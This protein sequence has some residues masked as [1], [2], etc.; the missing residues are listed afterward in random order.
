[1]C[2]AA[3]DRTSADPRDEPTEY[4]DLHHGVFDEERELAVNR[5]ECERH[6]NAIPVG[7]VR[8]ADDHNFF[9]QWFGGQSPTRELHVRAG[10]ERAYSHGV[11]LGGGCFGVVGWCS[12]M[13]G[14]EAHHA[15]VLP[16]YNGST[17]A[18]ERA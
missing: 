1:M 10:D 14:D 3:I 8:C 15:V 18:R 6:E 9:R 11:P 4:G 13:M 2:T 17:T 16:V 7:R 5:P 12:T